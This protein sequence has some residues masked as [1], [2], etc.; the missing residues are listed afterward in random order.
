[1]PL[2][3]PV[4]RCC[5]SSSL[6]FASI[7]TCMMSLLVLLLWLYDQW[8]CQWFIHRS[9]NERA[10][11]ALLLHQYNNQ[12]WCWY[13]MLMSMIVVTDHIVITCYYDFIMLWMM[14]LAMIFCSIHHQWNGVDLV[15]YG[16]SNVA[17]FVYI[18]SKIKATPISRI[19]L[20]WC[21]VSNYIGRRMK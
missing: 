8:R 2:I 11:V 20:C 13:I 12:P 19:K 3:V 5:N 4:P 18:G 15:S 21:W 9:S 10:S 1:M 17:V 16:R 14:Q 6:Y 7:Y